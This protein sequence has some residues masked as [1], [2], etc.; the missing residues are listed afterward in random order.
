[1]TDGW[2][3]RYHTQEEFLIG[4]MT[5]FMPDGDRER[6]MQHVGNITDE[7]VATSV[8]D[9]I[10]QSVVVRA[11]VSGLKNITL[12]NV[13]TLNPRWTFAE[14]GA[15]P[16]KFLL[17]IREGAQVGLFSADTVGWE[18]EAIAA[19]RTWLVEHMPEGVVVVA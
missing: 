3:G 10:S 1:M 2:A 18:Q 8:D 17:R 16:A 11:G 19:I 13:V 4:L 9:G 15:I 7:K 6:L 14:L 5:R 12:P